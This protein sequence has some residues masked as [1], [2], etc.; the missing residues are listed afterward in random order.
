MLWF[1]LRGYPEYFGMP[2]PVVSGLAA[3]AAGLAFY[4]GICYLLLKK[5]PVPFIRVL[6]LL[7]LLYCVATL[8]MLLYYWKTLTPLAVLYFVGEIILILLIVRVE[9]E[10]GNVEF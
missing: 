4:S 8:G 9:R 1:L 2:V 3:G 5:K 10:V 6:A 7:N